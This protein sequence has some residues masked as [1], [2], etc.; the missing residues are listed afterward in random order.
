MAVPPQENPTPPIPPSSLTP[1]VE[2][3]HPYG[4]AVNLNAPVNLDALIDSDVPVSSVT[5]AP[6]IPKTSSVDSI[7]KSFS[8]SG[9]GSSS[10]G[11]EVIVALTQGNVQSLGLQ[12]QQYVPV[13]KPENSEASKPV[14]EALMTSSDGPGQNLTD[15]TPKLNMGKD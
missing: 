13:S 4:A 7:F 5:K 9:E 8:H 3:A 14:T 2:F 12:E 6:P 15:V 10:K 1:P 11:K